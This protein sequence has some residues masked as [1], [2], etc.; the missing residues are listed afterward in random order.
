MM[1]LSVPDM[2]KQVKFINY[3]TSL[4]VFCNNGIWQLT[5]GTT[6]AGFS[7]DTFTVGKISNVGTYSA[8][9]IVVVES[10]VIFWNDAGIFMLSPTDQSGVFST[11]DISEATIKGFYSTIFKKA[12]DAAVGY[13][14]SYNKLVRW[15]Y[16]GDTTLLTG[17]YRDSELVLDI[18]LKAFY[19]HRVAKV[20]ADKNLDPMIMGYTQDRFLPT[21]NSYPTLKIFCRRHDSGGTVKTFFADYGNTDFKDWTNWASGAYF[22]SYMET[23]GDHVG[24]P[25]RDKQPIYVFTYF[26]KTE[27]GFVDNGSGGLIAKNPS[28]CL[29]SLKWDWHITTAGGKITTPRQVY[30][31]QRPYVPVDIN[32]TFNTGEGVIETKNKVKGKGKAVTYKFESENG[33]DFRLLGYSVPYEAPFKP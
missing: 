20:N 26:K 33:K 32:D 4:L 8:K 19:P 17:Q 22:A 13:Y 5:G 10:V 23:W 16:Q 30:R 29:M 21:L 28:S 9:S 25:V 18:K 15:A 3:G 1:V 31:F 11:E 6:D 27:D 12:K 2:G 24:D 14:D 7:A